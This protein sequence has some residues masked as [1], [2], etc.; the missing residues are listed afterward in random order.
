[1]E[2]IVEEEHDAEIADNHTIMDSRERMGLQRLEILLDNTQQI[3]YPGKSITG[4]I[5]LDLQTPIEVL[6]LRLKCKG[7]AQVY[8]TNRSAGFRRTYNA[9]ETYLH[10]EIYLHGDGKSETGIKSGSYPFSINLSENLPCSF[11]GRYG[12]VRYSIKAFLDVTTNWKTSTDFLAFT[13]APVF[14]LNDHQLAPLPMSE[15]LSKTFMGQTEPLSMSVFIP[16]RGYVP[17][18]TIPLEITLKNMS[19][20]DVKKLRIVFKKVVL[21]T[22]SVKVRKHKEII[23]EIEQPVDRKSEKYEAN[24]DVPAIPPSGTICNLIDV[25]YTLKVEA[26]VDVN[27]WYYRMFHKNLK[28]RTQVIVGTVPLSNYEDPL[29]SSDDSQSDFRTKKSQKE[30]LAL[31][32]GVNEIEVTETNGEVTN[33]EH[34]LK[35]QRSK[36]YRSSK[37]ERD[38]P[39]GDEGDSDGEVEPYS[40]MYRVY[41]FGGSR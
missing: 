24:V 21:Y 13:V 6:G 20:V 29:E 25:K 31:K 18:Q 27:E 16:V 1:M 12:R 17:G 7:E 33:S 30:T 2:K 28:I 10:E 5:V 14:N 37:P 9:G 26:C 15:T 39:T 4:R 34:V 8:F 40:P 38:D 35:Y 11:E 23:V 41:K 32:N 3:Y 22:S 19:H 36:I